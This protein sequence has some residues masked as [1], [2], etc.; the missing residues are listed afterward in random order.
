MYAREPRALFLQASTI[1]LRLRPGCCSRWAREL[2]LVDFPLET[3]IWCLGACESLTLKTLQGCCLRSVVATLSGLDGFRNYCTAA[4]DAPVAATAAVML[5]CCKSV[6]FINPDF[7]ICK[8]L[9]FPSNFL[10]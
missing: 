1:T 5:C 9:F 3:E 4:A 10:K 6:L 7:Q 2:A 8:F